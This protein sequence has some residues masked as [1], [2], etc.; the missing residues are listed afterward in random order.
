MS[1]RSRSDRATLRRVGQ[2]DE[3]LEEL[4]IGSG[5]INGGFD[6]SDGDDYTTLGRFVGEN[7]H[8][9]CLNF[10]FRYRRRIALGVADRGF[11]D[12][13]K[14]NTSI[15]ELKLA[16]NERDPNMVD[17]VCETL[18]AYQENNNLTLLHIV[19]DRIQN[20]VNNVITTTLHD[21]T[22]HPLTLILP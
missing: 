7:T 11:F 19:A 1:G 15:H 8:L 12:G 3:T 10:N 5:T 6:S 20:G 16:Y 13:L 18:K 22:P 4:Y 2:N 21:S 9:K 17:V 14:H